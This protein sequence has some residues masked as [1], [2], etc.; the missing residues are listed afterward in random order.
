MS[1]P[2][3]ILGAVSAHADQAD[4][5]E[6]FP[7]LPG[8]AAAAPA[9]PARVAG[10]DPAVWEA[11]LADEGVRAR[12]EAQVCREGG[13]HWYWTGTISST[14][15]GKLRV[16]TKAGPIERRVISAHVFGYQLHHGVLR[17]EPGVDLVVSHACDEHSCQ[18][19]D[20]LRAETRA[21]NNRERTARRG[22]GP[23]ADVR[24]PWGRAAAIR[25]AIREARRTGADVAAAIEAA[26]AAGVRAAPLPYG[27]SPGADRSPTAGRDSAGGVSGA[28]PGADDSPA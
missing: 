27:P 10:L 22:T 20:C 28:G 24:G 25:D 14:G 9:G 17:P 5:G 1:D 12:Y 26:A 19:P 8:V 21:A 4:Q 2:D 23:L 3:A 13:A 11:L 18:H 6:L 7:E 15:H 16:G